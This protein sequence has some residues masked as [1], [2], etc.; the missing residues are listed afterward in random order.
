MDL[1]A[2]LAR[3]AE[4]IANIG[5]K[6][7]ASVKA[8]NDA[9]PGLDRFILARSR[10]LK[11]LGA[12]KGAEPELPEPIELEPRLFASR[13]L[14]SSNPDLEQSDVK[15]DIAAEMEMEQA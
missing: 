11:Q 14:M 13:E 4:N 9:I 12:S 15:F 8:Y 7:Q 6:L 5:I 3:F 2:E 1:Y 10:T